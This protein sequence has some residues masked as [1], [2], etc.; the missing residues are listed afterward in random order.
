MFKHSIL[1]ITALSATFSGASPVELGENA[2]SNEL[3]ASSGYCKL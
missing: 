2:A 3:S 1:L